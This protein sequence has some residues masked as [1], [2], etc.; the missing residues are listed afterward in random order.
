MSKYDNE[1]KQLFTGK[2]DPASNQDSNYCALMCMSQWGVCEKKSPFQKLPHYSF[3]R[4]LG[5]SEGGGPFPGFDVKFLL[6]GHSAC[7]FVCMC[8]CVPA[9]IGACTCLTALYCMHT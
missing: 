3:L 7:M 5:F 8:L 2:F 1:E 9:C 4:G 6:G